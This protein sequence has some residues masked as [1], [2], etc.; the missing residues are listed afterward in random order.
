MLV[1]GGGVFLSGRGALVPRSVN[2]ASV[3]ESI[4]PRQAE[5]GRD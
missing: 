4:R 3:P 1:R 2:L 5:G